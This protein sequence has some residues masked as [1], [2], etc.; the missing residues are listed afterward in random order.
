MEDYLMTIVGIR[1]D[2]SD[3]QLLKVRE[4]ASKKE[5]EA[6]VRKMA[7]YFHTG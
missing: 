3:Y 2:Y 6:S 5:M 1:N 7:M 4:N